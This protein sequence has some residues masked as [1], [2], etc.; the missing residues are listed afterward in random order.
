MHNDFL[1]IKSLEGELK[2][3]H[4]KRDFGIT[5]STK[6]LVY[7]KPRVN[8]VIRLEDIV[9]IMPY[10]PGNASGPEKRPRRGSSP[11]E[12]AGL[13]TSVHHH[14][15]YTKMS[16]MHS[17]SGIFPLGPMEYILPVW[18]ELLRSIARY[19]NLEAF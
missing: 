4:K 6:E 8:Y 19:A 1:K 3:S 7:Q 12:A 14:R 17:R 9:S 13:A 10:R 15:I 18:P 11:R 16:T 2:W 5:V